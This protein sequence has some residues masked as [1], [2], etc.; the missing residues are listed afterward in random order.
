LISS[1]SGPTAC[2]T[3]ITRPDRGR[4]TLYDWWAPIAL[5]YIKRR[6]ASGSVHEVH[7]SLFLP[8]TN[9]TPDLIVRGRSQRWEAPLDSAATPSPPLHHHGLHCVTSSP[10]VAAR[11]QPP[12]T[13]VMADTGSSSNA[14]APPSDGLYTSPHS[15]LSLIFSSTCTRTCIYLNVKLNPT[16]LL[17]YDPMVLTGGPSKI[18]AAR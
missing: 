18:R 11:A 2:W 12:S 10:T 17:L 5:R 14:T 16:D 4:P 8:P 7:Q 9:P 15:S 6:E 13:N 1:P 3:L